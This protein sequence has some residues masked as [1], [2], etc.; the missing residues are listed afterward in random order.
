MHTT[1]NAM[2]TPLNFLVSIVHVLPKTASELLD[3]EDNDSQILTGHDY[4]QIQ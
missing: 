2:T 3:T 1:S 4:Q